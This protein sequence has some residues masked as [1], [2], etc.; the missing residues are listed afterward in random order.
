M[1]KD[2]VHSYDG[3]LLS[4][5]KECNLTICNNVDALEGIMLNKISE[6]ERQIWYDLTDM[7]NLNK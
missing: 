1:E 7:W 4:H 5:K 3:I 6:T 2:V